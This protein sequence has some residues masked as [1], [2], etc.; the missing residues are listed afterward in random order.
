MHALKKEVDL[1]IQYAA[2]A[3]P[4]VAQEAVHLRDKGPLQ[5]AKLVADSGA[6][7]MDIEEGIS[8]KGYAAAGNM[9]P[10]EA[11]L[12]TSVAGCMCF[13]CRKAADMEIGGLWA[14]EFEARAHCK[15]TKAELT[16]KGWMCGGCRWVA[17]W[18]TPTLP[19]SR[20]SRKKEIDW[21]VESFE[22]TVSE[23]YEVLFLRVEQD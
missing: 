16:M 21:L 12:A 14:T 9:P 22:K 19:S 2:Q 15:V 7:A 11:K 10:K 18:H 6:S 1:S 23:D 5:G 8:P 3:W 4:R 20:E 17:R 13:C